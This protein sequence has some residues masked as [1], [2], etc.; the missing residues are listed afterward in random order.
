MRTRRRRPVTLSAAAALSVRLVEP[1]A[2]GAVRRGM[3]DRQRLELDATPT[4]LSSR[5][6]AWRRSSP[7]ATS[8]V[9]DSF[10][11]TPRPETPGRARA[12]LS[13]RIL[14]FADIRF[15]LE[16]ANGIQTMETCHAL[17]SAG[18][19]CDLVVRPDT[20]APARDPFA[21]YGLP[22][23]PRLIIERAPVAGPA[24]RTPRRLLSF[25]VGRVWGGRADVLITRDLGVGG[26]AAARCRACIRAA[27][28]LRIA[29][30]RAGR[31]GRAAGAG[32]HRASARRRAKLKRLARA[33][34]AVWRDADG[35]VTI[36]RDWPR[37]SRAVR[38]ALAQL[39]VVPDGVRVNS[40]DAD[41]R[42]KHRTAQ[43]V[44]GYAGH[45]YAW[46]G[47]DVLL[48]ALARA[49]RPRAD[50]RRTRRG[51]RTSR[52]SARRWPA[53]LGIADRVT[54]TGLVGP[55]Q[56]AGASARATCWCCRTRRRRSRRGSRRR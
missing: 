31:R 40:H 15:P 14:Y 32:R 35:Y 18:T 6:R 56:R 23:S 30:L 11:Q 8:S 50:R 10:Y 36:T 45:L 25:A 16:R 43:V 21:F 1:R 51:S 17:A 24:V 9:A 54:F 2:D 55:A 46:K 26:V 53:A 20:H 28:R 41:S 52:A 47:V 34:G 13:V 3:M 22:R 7:T 48:E 5:C 4:M 27:G 49:R 37:D 39:A 44:V 12:A 42:A 19:T 38:Q 29:R 33:R